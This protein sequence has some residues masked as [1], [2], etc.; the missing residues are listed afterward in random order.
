MGYLT[1][2]LLIPNSGYYTA[3][4]ATFPAGAQVYATVDSINYATTYGAVPESNEGNNVFG[5]VVS[6]AAGSLSAGAAPQAAPAE[7]P[8]R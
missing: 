7:M 4:S 2:S 1:G 6:T 8:E 3:G 5:P